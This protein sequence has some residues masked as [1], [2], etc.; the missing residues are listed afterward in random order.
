MRVCYKQIRVGSGTDVWAESLASSL[1]KTGHEADI[2]FYSKL[3]QITPHL[4]KII[5]KKD[6][7]DVVHVKTPEGFALKAGGIP[8]LVTAHL[9]VHDPA[10]TPY[11]SGRQRLVHPLW[12]RYEKRCFEAAD[13]ITFPSRFTMESY[14]KTFGMTD[15]RVIHN[16]VDTGFYKPMDVADNPYPD[17]TVLFF[18]GNYSMRKG[19]D[20]LPKIMGELGDG[21]VL[22][23]AGLR[24]T[25]GR[26]PH[27]MTALGRLEPEKLRH[28][29]NIADTYLFP[30][31][32]EGLSLSTLEAMSCGL[33]V[34]ASD[35]TSF[36]E[37][38]DDGRG[39]F[40][41]QTDDVPSFVDRV[42]Y[43]AESEGERKKMGAY[44]RGRAVKDFSL[45]MMG[46]KYLRLYEE[47]TS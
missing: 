40:L 4:L 1:R 44:N 41:C 43:L 28:Y 23:L 47:V 11:R 34:V 27:N 39:G 18:C 2:L 13:E 19:A 32:L 15:G 31:R 33:P 3:F 17:K 12:K 38:V 25:P 42:R 37:L 36:P 21:Y 29:Y 6:V 24:D 5:D 30:S 14:Q 16:G 9:N 35:A 8:L 7:C 45:D 10:F 22:L 46:Q 20:L 26:L